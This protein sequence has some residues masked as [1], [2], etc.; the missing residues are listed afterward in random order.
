VLFRSALDAALEARDEGSPFDIIL[1][2]MQ[3]PVMDGY[4]ST[5]ALRREGYLGPII[6]LTAHAMD[7][8]RDKCIKVGCDDYATK[9]IDRQKL[10]DLMK[11][12]DVVIYD[13]YYCDN[14]FEASRALGHSTWQEGLRLCNAAGAKRLVAFQHSPRHDDKTLDAMQ[15]SLDEQ[16]PGSTV[17][18]E[19]LVVDV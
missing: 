19:G 17:A 2:D 14:E 7:G 12:A 6:A 3:M 16:N 13:S 11:D 9:P 1:M 15:Q 4:D 5:T 18:F 10:I 8:D